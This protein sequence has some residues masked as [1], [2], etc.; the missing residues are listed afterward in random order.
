VLVDK[1]LQG[2]NTNIVAEVAGV[3]VA[4]VYHYFPD[5][6]SILRE[7]FERNEAVR[8]EFFVEHLALLPT[9]TD[10][11]GWMTTAV[12]TLLRF[13]R[14]EPG[15]P[16]LRRAWRAVPELTALEEQR[17]TELVAAVQAAFAERFPHQPAA[18]LKAA[19]QITLTAAISVLDQYVDQPRS[20]AMVAREL[21]TMLV[22]YLEQLALPAD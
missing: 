22:G 14:Q 12:E 9:T 13:R 4:T 7:L 5:K 1:G 19:A 20:H 8:V 10:L 15:G 17:N 16:V 11:P 6:N 2:F 18:R 3:N 21:S